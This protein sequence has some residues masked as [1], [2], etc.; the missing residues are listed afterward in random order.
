MSRRIVIAL[1][2][3][4]TLPIIGVGIYGAVTHEAR[5][6]VPQL[7]QS[8]TIRLVYTP[9]PVTGV[10]YH[11]VKDNGAMAVANKNPLNVKGKDWQ[12]QVGSDKFGHAQFK[13][14]EYGI[15][16]AALTLRSYAMRHKIDTLKGIVHRF[17]E[18]NREQYIR[19]L[20]RRLGLKADEKF[21]LITRMPDLLRAMARFECGQDLPDELFVPYDI[22]EK[23]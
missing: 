8:M 20:G 16:A 19:F 10:G 17:A 13:S 22:L 14:W 15:R 21:N 7:P 6:T 2:V 12:G 9:D 23:L 3:V 5:A 18:G 11:E 1:A 4:M